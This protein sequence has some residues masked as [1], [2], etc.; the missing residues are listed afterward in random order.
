MKINRNINVKVKLM[1]EFELKVKLSKKLRWA[2]AAL[3][4][5]V[6]SIAKIN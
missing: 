3:E 1:A 4:V 5:E 2:E 6:Y